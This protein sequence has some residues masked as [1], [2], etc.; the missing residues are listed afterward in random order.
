MVS[1]L[2]RV[3]LQK[4]LRK[5]EKYHRKMQLCGF[6]KVFCVEVVLEAPREVQ[7]NQCGGYREPM[8]HM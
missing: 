6:Q 1:A 8:I 4:Q 5:D 2:S 7:D 3:Q